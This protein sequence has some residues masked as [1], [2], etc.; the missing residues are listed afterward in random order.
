[1]KTILITILF[2]MTIFSSCHK[3]IGNWSDNIHL[4]G[5]KFTFNANGDSVLITTK[6][7]WWWLTFA[8]LDST[9]TPIPSNAV[10]CDFE[11]TDSSF[12]IVRKSCDTLIVKINENNTN[13]SRVLTIGL[14]AGDY[15]DAVQI[16][17]SFR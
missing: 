11:Y 5:K 6:G 8:K 2:L 10:L 1:M 15:F 13:A 16:T 4:S 17:Q 14:E 12:Q 3:E 9:Y 7:K